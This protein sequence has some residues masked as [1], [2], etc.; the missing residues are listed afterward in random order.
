MG[1]KE[2]NNNIVTKEQDEVEKYL[3]RIIQRYFDIENNYS[4]ESIEAIILEALTRFKQIIV[5]ESGFMFS[6]NQMTGKLTLDISTFGGEPAF[7]KKTAFN[8]NFGDVENTVCEGNDER[9]YNDREPL[10]HAHIDIDIKELENKIKTIVVPD[11]KDGHTHKNKDVIDMLKYTG[12]QT[13]IDLIVIEYLQKA[14]NEYIE[15][16]K[17]Y[18][19]ELGTIQNTALE[20][21]KQYN[22]TLKQIIQNGQ[23]LADNSLN[24][25]SSAYKVS[26]DMI[27][28]YT[29]RM[30]RT[31]LEY[32]SQLQIQ[33]LNA[34]FKRAYVCVKEG[35]LEL[36]NDRITMLPLITQNITRLNEER[37]AT[38]TIDEMQKESN[39]LKLYFRYDKDGSTCT[40][41]LP[42]YLHVDSHEIVIQGLCS[43]G[44]EVVVTSIVT[45]SIPLYL[46]SSGFYQKNTFIM[47]SYIPIGDL[48]ATNKY[49]KEIGCILTKIDSQDKND[50]ISRMTITDKQYFIN[51]VR[52]IMKDEFHFYDNED[53]YELMAYF[54]WE[55]GYPKEDDYLDGISIINDKWR[56]VDRT[57]E[58]GFIAE[59]D[60]KRLSQYFDNPRIYY[61]VLGNKEAM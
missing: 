47:A 37:T 32:V 55:D 9:L 8:K 15:N 36:S 44:G 10:E 19:R 31:L 13:T 33:S 42:F 3:M 16:L 28:E 4:K 14:I 56:N 34:T 54:N 6:L 57:D 7:N 61:Q 58:H 45:D 26:D 35:E 39:R 41:P 52:S 48:T 12:Q 60:V 1:L 49:L 38:A 25:L 30:Q 23:T 53:N 27:S 40:I 51:G 2:H 43:D 22:V 20:K 11:E 24:W 5:S 17:A 29:Q 21:L 46:T 50:F 18:N 59:Y